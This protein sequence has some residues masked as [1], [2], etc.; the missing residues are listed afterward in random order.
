MRC[1]DTPGM[2]PFHD[3][4]RPV[5]EQMS[6]SPSAFDRHEALRL[7]PRQLDIDRLRERDSGAFR[8]A[9]AKLFDNKPVYV[10]NVLKK[11]S[12]RFVDERITLRAAAPELGV[13]NPDQIAKSFQSKGLT[14]AG[15]MELGSGGAVRRDTWEDFYDQVAEQFGRGVPVIPIDG[16]TR[17]DYERPDARATF[18]LTTSRQTVKEG[19]VQVITVKNTSAQPIFVEMVLTG[20]E[21]QKAV[22]TPDVVSVAAGGTLKKGF[23]TNAIKG[24]DLITVYASDTKFEKGELLVFPEAEAQKGLGM[25]ARFIHRQ[26][27]KLSANGGRLRPEFDPSRMVKKTVE[28]ET[29]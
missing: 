18:T 6:G 21:G 23:K 20:T 26:F 27:Y 4:I 13:T 19:D 24:K 10:Q 29:Q 15:L 1:H 5:L 16:V 17:P 8:R 28:I 9:L 12:D 14:D 11:V 25:G 2:K 3:D 7:Y 22:V